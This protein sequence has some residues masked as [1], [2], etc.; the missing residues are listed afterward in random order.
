M[1][2]SVASSV[3]VSPC[4]DAV[5][6]LVIVTEE[7]LHVAEEHIES[8]EQQLADTEKKVTEANQK[9]NGLQCFFFQ[10][11]LLKILSSMPLHGNELTEKA[12]WWVIIQVSDRA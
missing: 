3:S 12:V 11:F 8:L 5:V 6:L 2:F 4:D 10:L 1:P 7:K 9:G